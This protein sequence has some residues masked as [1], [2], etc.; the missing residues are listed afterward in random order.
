MQVTQ[1]QS[2]G[3][4][5]E[6]KV[7]ISAGDI[8]TKVDHRL[9]E[10]GSTVKL[11]GFRPGKVPMPVL[12]KRF[13]QSVLGEVLER[14]ISDSSGQAMMERGLR[15]ALTPKIAID[16]FSE[17]NDLEY[18]VAVEVLPEITPM[19]FA[20]LQLARLKVM[21]SEDE[22]TKSVERI[23]ARNKKSEP[24][25]EDRATQKEDIV[26]IDF[27]GTVDG[28]A[29]PGMKGEDHQLELGSGEFIAG[30]EDQ[31]IGHKP[32]DKTT[33]KV[34]FPDAYDNA[35]LAGKEAAFAVTVKAIRRKLP[36]AVDDELAKGMGLDDLDTLRRAVRREIEQ[37]Y[38]QISRMRLKRTL[39]DKLAEQHGFAVPP[40][41][42]EL[43]FEAIW[44]NLERERAQGQADPS[45]AGKSD[46]EL[47]AEF[48]AIAE[49][50]VRLGLLL[51]DV[52]QR[53]NIQVTPEEV[54]RAILTEA[55]RFPGQERRVVEFYR[56]N[57]EAMSQI[58]APLFEEKVVDFILD[59]AKV[60]E[61]E[62]DLSE[63]MRDPDDASSSP[64]AAPAPG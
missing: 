7:V 38:A 41:M 63:L 58:R 59:Q 22:V 12:K 19:D 28:K 3:L 21:V 52:G 46:D 9:Q 56:Q 57:N 61:R 64:A 44:K 40:G 60:E 5:H 50:R 26:V 2:D 29:L 8:Q 27:D 17:G 23:A 62:V 6:F 11:P 10:L 1:T 31:L 45:L 18:T 42:V 54:N 49:R 15:P 4:K 33:V 14:A 30:F 16:K 47:K 43:E 53:N 36:V 20:Q 32:G 55:R 51:S 39:L 25:D 34:R 48:R 35:E 37:Q 13:G 24:V